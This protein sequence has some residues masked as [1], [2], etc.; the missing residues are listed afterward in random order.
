MIDVSYALQN[1]RAYSRFLTKE[2]HYFYFYDPYDATPEVMSAEESYL[3][4]LQ[5]YA[6]NSTAAENARMIEL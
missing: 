5:W 6:R 1:G 4:D 3:L 2:K